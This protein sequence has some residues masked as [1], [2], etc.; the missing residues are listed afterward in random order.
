MMVP[1][2]W[3]GVVD[4]ADEAWDYRL[5][6]TFS[7]RLAEV[8][9]EMDEIAGDLP[10]LPEIPVANQ[11]GTGGFSS[12]Y[13]KHAGK[14]GFV[15]ELT[16]EEIGLVDLVALVPARRYG[17]TG[18]DPEFGLPD[19]FSV[20]LL[21]SDGG[22]VA[23]VANVDGLWGDPVRNGH[24]LLFAVDPPVE[25]AGM[26]I[27]ARKLKLSSDA[28]NAVVHAWAEAF[29]FEGERNLAADAEVVNVRGVTPPSPWHWAPSFLVDGQTPLG[30]PEVPA[31]VHANV[32]WISSGRARETDRVWLEVDLGEVREI[33][34]VRLFPAKRP[35][36]DL[37]SGF[38]FPR[39]FSVSVSEG[40]FD[41]ANPRPTLEKR[42][43][44][45]NPGHNPVLIP[46]QRFRGRFLKIEALR[47]WKVHE[48]Y[49]AF[50]ALSEV[51][52]LD[53]TV[54][55]ARGA[56]VRSPDGMEN[57]V[58]S[59]SGYW[60]VASLCDG[61]GP[62]GKLVS[63]REWL[64]ALG[65]RLK[66]EQRQ[67]AL[68]VERREIVAGWRRLVVAGAGLLGGVG[69]FLLVALPVRYRL[70]EKREVERVRER[71]ASDLHDEVGSNLGSIQMFA[72]LAE[73]RTGKSLELTRIQRIAAET[74]SAVRDIVWLLRPEGDS[75]IGTV[76]HLRETSSIMLERLDW[77]FTA[78]EAAWQ[79][80]LTDEQSRHLFLFFR[81]ALHN[82]LR[83]AGA[84]K[85]EVRVECGDDGFRLVVADDGCGISEKKLARKSTLRALRQR[86]DSLG[87]EM[88]VESREGEGTRLE[89][90]IPM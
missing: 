84:E 78:N 80:E 23:Q 45:A 77:K 43:E 39:V 31:G 24:P 88:T 83:H 87:A 15:V 52:A 90:V 74:V 42:V 82:V 18:L 4:G 55:V 19:A 46:L 64:E 27:V 11:G 67:H 68:G 1:L 25:A 32:G 8:E 54:N 47:L 22:V 58:A 66:L 7:G 61:F 17:V 79:A 37:P 33:D 34:G 16:F 70:R 49:P 6:R 56:R 51:E 60:S 5:A 57:V 3:A 50:Y 14:D 59:A 12:L 85:A 72:D 81:E 48:R 65:K 63:R 20:E 75:R 41:P 69:V 71:I 86:V 40:R 53:G 13:P 29:A 10:G 2:F 89:L 73:G 26:R 21:D 38:G 62:E 44:M 36:A 9:E 28:S 35:T 30:L 76:E